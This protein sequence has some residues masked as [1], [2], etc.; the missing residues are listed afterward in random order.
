MLVR[1]LTRPA[2]MQLQDWTDVVALD[3][4]GIA[5]A[6]LQDDDWQGWAAQLLNNPATRGMVPGPYQFDEWQEWAERLCGALA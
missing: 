1:A 2:N 4:T 3:L 6:P 5:L